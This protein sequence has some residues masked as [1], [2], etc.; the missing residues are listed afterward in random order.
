MSINR[1]QFQKGLSM[2]EFFER[3]GSEDQCHAALVAL[4][5]PDGFGRLGLFKY[6]EV[7]DTSRR[8]HSSRS[9]GGR[10]EVPDGDAAQGIVER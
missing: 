9:V 8:R 3:Y 1:V 7:V 2:A 5:W 6:P 10:R 4:R